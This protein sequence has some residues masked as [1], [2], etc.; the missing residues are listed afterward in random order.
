MVFCGAANNK[1]SVKTHGTLKNLFSKLF[2]APGK[3]NSQ[4]ELKIDRP[5]VGLFFWSTL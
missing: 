2:Q 3:L 5:G 4:R 1:Y